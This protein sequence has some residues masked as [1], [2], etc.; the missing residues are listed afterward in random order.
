M[1]SARLTLVAHA[2]TAATAEAGFP[3]DEGLEPRGLAAARAARGGLRRPTR[4]VRSPAT[5][6]AETAD[7]LGL[8]ATVDLGLA[9]WDLG[10]WRGRT[11][12]ELAAADPAAVRAWL[13]E[14]GAAP[15]GGESL[16]ALLAR[17]TAWLGSINGQEECPGDRHGDRDADRDGG[18]G[19]SGGGHSGGGRSGG[20]HSAGGHVV[21]V[22]HAAV[23][24]AAVVVTLDAPPAAFWRIDIAPLTAT[25]LR[26]GA[27]RWTLRGTALPLGA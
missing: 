22:T 21:A 20:G 18:G 24:R 10:A 19:R 12:D 3:A 9:D 5:A 26:G 1:V 25:V 11:L 23:V 13:T 27:G 2:S 14:P 16:A 4:V 6:A 8:A 15:H 7:A 17:V